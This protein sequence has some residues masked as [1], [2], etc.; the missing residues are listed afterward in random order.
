MGDLGEGANEFDRE[1]DANTLDA[2][3]ENR[4]RSH[5]EHHPS[6]EDLFLLKAIYL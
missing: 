1:M 6:A 5:C 2:N 3:T 4:K